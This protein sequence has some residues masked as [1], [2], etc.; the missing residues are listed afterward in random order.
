MN[1]GTTFFL[2]IAVILMGIPV[3]ALCI[4][5]VPEVGSY[6]AE[7]YPDMAYIKY[8]IFIDLYAAAIPFYIALYQAFKLL[9]YIDK[10]KAF[11]IISVKALKNIKYCAITI[12]ILYVGGMPLLYLIAEKDD[13][14]GIILIGLVIIFASM[15]IGVF[16]AVLQKLLKE[17]IDIK[18]ENDLTV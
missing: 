10:N 6:A 7:L 12:S 15:V 13:A 16:A 14:P 17:A 5:L 4:F 18:S 3:L 2:K 8:L 11:S 1:K 9:S